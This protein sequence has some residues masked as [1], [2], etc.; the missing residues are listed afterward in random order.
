MIAI[1]SDIHGNY[2]ALI[3]VLNKINEK[4]I[5]EVYCLVDIVGYYSQVN[6]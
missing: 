6:E 4:G 3:S 1:I 5:N 2:P